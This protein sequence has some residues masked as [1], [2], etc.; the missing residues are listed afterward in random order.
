MDREIGFIDINNAEARNLISGCKDEQGN[1]LL[2]KYE[3]LS[4]NDFFL[5]FDNGPDLKSVSVEKEESI[6]D[7]IQDEDME[8]YYSEDLKMGVVYVYPG[9]DTLYYTRNDGAE[10]EDS[11]SVDKYFFY[12]DK[13]KSQHLSD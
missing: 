2:D 9:Q 11:A 3:D 7:L 5:D 8:I 10:R 4:E 6:D 1:T 13:F 12:N